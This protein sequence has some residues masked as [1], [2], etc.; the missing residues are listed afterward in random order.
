MEIERARLTKRLAK[1][2]EEDGAIDEAADILQEVAVVRVGTR[3]FRLHLIWP[4]VPI[5]DM[6]RNLAVTDPEHNTLGWGACFRRKRLVRWRRRKRSH[7]SWS[8]CSL[9]VNHRVTC[10][11]CKD[12]V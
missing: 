2:K 12:V 10:V 7:S 11:L 1:I 3:M 9:V 8:R 4:P 6:L 5:T